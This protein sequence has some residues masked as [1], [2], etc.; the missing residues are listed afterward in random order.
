MLK[1]VA[2]AIVL[3]VIFSKHGCN[4]NTTSN[5]F[6]GKLVIKEQCSHYVVQVLSARIDSSL[7][8]NEWR[9]EKRNLTF[10]NVFSVS[11]RCSFP[12]T[13]EEGATFDFTLVANPQTED[14]VVCLAYY[15]TP[16]KRNAIRVT[17]VK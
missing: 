12:S 7:V 2:V 15:P 1:S 10:S 8:T 5:T 4:K 16:P 3:S 17:S 13:L 6:R 11:N 14:C 9:D